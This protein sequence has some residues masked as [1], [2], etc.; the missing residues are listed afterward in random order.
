ML[1]LFSKKCK[2][3][4]RMTSKSMKFFSYFSNL[5]KFFS[6][7]VSN[8]NNQ[9]FKNLFANFEIE[10][11]FESEWLR[12]FEICMNVQL[13]FCKSGKIWILYH[14]NIR[15]PLIKSFRPP[16]SCNHDRTSHMSCKKKAMFV[17]RYFI[18]LLVST[19]LIGAIFLHSSFF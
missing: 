13:K 15:I 3:V 11:Y 14:K 4:A 16:K 18:Q 12:I 7:N 10:A 5:D 8:W 2:L 9:K 1:N 6:T 17:D 19:S